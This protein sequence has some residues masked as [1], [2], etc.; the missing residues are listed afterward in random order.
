MNHSKKELSEFRLNRANETI[1]DAVFMSEKKRWNTTVNRLYYA[2]FYAISAYLVL[3][4]IKSKTHKG[5]KT[6]FNNELIRAGK[7]SEEHGELYNKLFEFRHDA[8][9]EDFIIFTEEE[10]APLIFQT[11]AFLQAISQLI[12]STNDE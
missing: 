4:D 6:Q 8:D 5:A 12:K 2:C 11:Q 9:Y 10:V 3:H 1:E 7:L